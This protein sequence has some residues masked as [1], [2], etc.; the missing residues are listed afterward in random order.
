MSS[1]VGN[2]I[3]VQRPNAGYRPRRNAGAP[4][5]G[6]L[7][8]RFPPARLASFPRV[9]TA[10]PRLIH[11]QPEVSVGDP[12]CENAPGRTSVAA[13]SFRPYNVNTGPKTTLGDATQNDGHI[14]ETPSVLR[15]IYN[16]FS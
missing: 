5:V 4:R 11:A 16:V 12:C 7:L 15:T 13:F 3:H 1:C 6:L 8:I 9:I 2:D 10:Q 14:D